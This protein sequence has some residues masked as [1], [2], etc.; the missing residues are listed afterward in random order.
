MYLP[1]G[2]DSSHWETELAAHYPL[3]LSEMR[4]PSHPLDTIE[5]RALARLGL[6]CRAGWRQVL[7]RLLDKLEAAIRAQ[8]ADQRDDFRIVQLKERFGRLTVYQDRLGTAENA[9]RDRRSWRYVG[10][11]LRGLR[12]ARAPRRTERLLVREVRGPRELVAIRSAALAG[13]LTSRSQRPETSIELRSNELE[14]TLERTPE[15]TLRRGSGSLSPRLDLVRRSGMIVRC[16][17]DRT[18]PPRSPARCRRRPPAW[19]VT[20]PR[21][22][23]ARSP[24]SGGWP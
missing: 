8:P 13:Q 4:W 2:G 20:R 16:A 12:R 18:D 14:G 22:P 5:A 11:D 23:R 1:K 7:V 6:E 3:A 21:R 9:R 24:T 10:R 15:G 19:P 17:A